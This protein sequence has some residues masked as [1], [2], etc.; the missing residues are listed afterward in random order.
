MVEVGQLGAPRQRRIGR[1]REAQ[2]LGHVLEQQIAQVA[3]EGR[4]V[5]VEVGDEE[6]EPA[7]GV[8]IAGRQAH[9]R[10]GVAHGVEGG[11]RPQPD[12]L[13][14]AAL[15][16][17]EVVGVRV[18]GG[19][20]VE[21]EIAV[22]IGGD[23]GEGVEETD[24]LETGAPG[25]LAEAAS[26][27]VLPEEIGLALETEGSEHDLEAFP[28][29]RRL[30]VEHVGERA[31]DVGADEEILVAVAVGVEEDRAGRPAVD[32]GSSV[33]ALEGAVAA[34]AVEHVGAEVADEEIGGAVAV[35]VARRDPRPPALI[36]NPGGGA[37]LDEAPAAVV[38]IEAVGATLH[39]LAAGE[40]PAVDHVE[41]EV[42]VAVV[43][44]QRQAGA[45][46]LEQVRLLRTAAPGRLV[47]AGGDGD[48]ADRLRRRRRV[49][50][51]R[52]GQRHGRG[53]G[54]QIQRDGARRQ[55]SPWK[56][57]A[58]FSKVAQASLRPA[59]SAVRIAAEASRILFLALRVTM[60]NPS[61]NSPA[62]SPAALKW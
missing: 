27:G 8:E 31:V 43:V 44:D 53:D 52:R 35:D 16:V 30:G 42:A 40:A 48:E 22:E 61:S 41:V 14:A 33:Y 15:V 13:E 11:A 59:S 51:G 24:V 34:V 28:V 45:A 9:A 20:E 17:V 32:A 21:V 19:V 38:A 50:A 49:G 36:G 4:D 29:E 60:T 37:H 47:D 54:D 2:V 1:S 46:R 7:V 56:P 18:V 57:M 23:D 6:V 58:I 25:A 5:L 3:V 62:S 55:P 39:H 10:L 26:A 12:L